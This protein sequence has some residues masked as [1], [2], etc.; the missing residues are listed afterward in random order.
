MTEEPFSL[1]TVQR[2]GDALDIARNCLLSG[3]TFAPVTIYFI[4][5]EHAHNDEEQE[6]LLVA[7]L[8]DFESARNQLDVEFGVSRRG[9]WNGET[10]QW[11]AQTERIPISAVAD[12]AWWTV[13][14]CE[15]FLAASKEDRETPFFLILG[16]LR[17]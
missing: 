16:I 6:R 11:D 10:R 8:S 4:E 13:D 17:A 15:L 14:G 3:A 12:A 5:D 2:Y 1:S 9:E 7:L